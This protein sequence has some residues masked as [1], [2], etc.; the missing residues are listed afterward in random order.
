MT[1]LR[2]L[3]LVLVATTVLV[4]CGK[5]EKGVEQPAELVDIKATLPVQKLWSSSVGGGG[6]NL[7]LALGL[8]HSAGTI[9]AAGRGGSV[10]ALYGDSGKERWKTDTKLEL[11]AGPGVGPGLVAVGTNDGDV[12]AFDPLTGKRLWNVKVSSE[13]LARPL[14]TADRVVVRTVDGRLR[15]LSAANGKELWMLEEQVPRLTLRGTSPP[16]LSGDT[17]LCGFDSGKVL[18]VSLQTGDI[19]WQTQASTPRGRSELERLADVDAPVTS[20]GG[21]IFAVGYQGRLAMLAADSGQVWWGRDLSSYRGV[22]L[23]DQRVY[24]STSDGDVIA[25][26]RRD[27]TALWTQDALRRRNLSGPALDG[28]AI[29][30]GDYDGYVHW[31]D[32]ETG[33][34][35]GRERGGGDRISAAPLVTD[36]R[37]YVLDDGGVV[38]AFRSGA[39]TGR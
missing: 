21:D 14:V 36:G 24:A 7:R 39:R 16:V 28:S 31:L 27:G 13:V 35:I 25:M 22:V 12:L 6:E 5:K 26:R 15:A 37:V 17:V 20:A 30:V 32:T 33:K 38:T 18:A 4:A 3:T 19:L 10:V 9:Y 29:V 8:A 11:S 1:L 2:K 34:I 23:D